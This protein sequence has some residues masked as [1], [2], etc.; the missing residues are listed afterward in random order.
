MAESLY[1]QLSKMLLD[2][3]VVRNAMKKARQK[4]KNEYDKNVRKKMVEYYLDQYD[5]KKYKR[6]KVSPLLSAYRT[7]SKIINSGKSVELWVES[8][9]IDISKYYKDKPY[10]SHSYYHGG[11]I[12][13]DDSDDGGS[14]GKWRE[15]TEIHKMSGKQYMLQIDDL[16]EQYGS[17]NGAVM[18]SWII[19]NF[20]KGIH[21]RTNGWPRKKYSRQM[22]YMPKRD[23][24]TPWQMGEKYVSDFNEMDMI[25]QYLRAE[26]YNEW[27]KKFK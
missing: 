25:K 19:E 11:D 24:K 16:R 5:P 13:D 15:M 22:K 9:G 6:H 7:R 2:D 8:T 4:I 3:D 27:K 18:G 17:K 23:S 12:E 26:L 21:P 10:K 20:D 1:S 14:S